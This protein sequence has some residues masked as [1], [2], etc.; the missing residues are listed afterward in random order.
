MKKQQAKLELS[1]EEQDRLDSYERDEWR[2][3]SHL[4]EKRQQYQAYASAALEDDN[5]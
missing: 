3:V 1:P 4:Q 2:S 5:L